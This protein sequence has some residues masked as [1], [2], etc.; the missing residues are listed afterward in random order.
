MKIMN[1]ILTYKITSNSRM[2]KKLKKCNKNRLLNKN[3]VV[4]ENINK[5]NKIVGII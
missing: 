3:I 5:I 2:N 4:E 1:K